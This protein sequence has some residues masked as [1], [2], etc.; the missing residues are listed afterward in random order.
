MRKPNCFLL[1]DWLEY[2]LAC[3]ACGVSPAICCYDCTTKYQTQMIAE[4]KCQ[5]PETVFVP[6]NG[7]FVGKRPGQRKIIDD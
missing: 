3:S 7:S 6:W 2:K 1:D 4:D 5:H